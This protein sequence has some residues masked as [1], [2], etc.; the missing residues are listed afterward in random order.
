MVMLKKDMYLHV[1]EGRLIIEID[2]TLL[3]A[4]SVCDERNADQIWRFI[5]AYVSFLGDSPLPYPLNRKP[6]KLVRKF[7]RE[8]CGGPIRETIARYA[9]LAEQIIT[10]CHISGELPLTGEFV[11][12][13]TNTPVFKEYHHFY[14]TGDPVTLQ[15]ILS[16]LRFGKKMDYID[17]S[18]N[19]VA[20]RD[21][22][23]VENRLQSLSLPHYVS[24]I[25]KLMRELLPWIRTDSFYPKFG[26][27]AVANRGVRG[28]ISKACSLRYDPLI[29]RAFFS[30][31]YKKGGSPPP[32]ASVIPDMSLWMDSSRREQRFS[33]YRF[34]PKDVAKSRSI[35]ME[36]NTVMY[37]QQLV[38]D[39]MK[40]SI[41]GGPLRRFIHLDDQDWNRDAARHGS[42]YG[43]MDTLDLSSA[44]DSVS[45]DLVKEI[46]PRE[47]LYY[48]LATRTH[49]VR[50]P[51]KVFRDVK[52]FAP[53]GSA[54]CF[55][56]QCIIFCCVVLYAMMLYD[57][58]NVP[59]TLLAPEMLSE[60][61]VRTFLAKRV[62]RT[63]DWF[64][65]FQDY[66]ECPQVFGDDILCDSRVTENVTRILHDL[67]FVVNET[68]SFRGS[69]A[70]RES[71]GEWYYFGDRVTPFTYRIEHSGEKLTPTSFCSL[72]DAINNCFDEGYSSLR[73]V[74]I[75]YALYTRLPPIY[76]KKWK[77]GPRIRVRS[78]PFGPN[79]VRFVS[80]REEFGILAKDCSNP[81]LL[82][83]TNNRWQV[84]EVLCVG[85]VVKKVSRPESLE[86]EIFDAYLY[87]QDARTRYFASTPP[88]FI[89][90][91]AKYR[92]EETG[93]AGRW[94]PCRE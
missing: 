72:I 15:F 60:E 43:S 53:M 31:F 24:D 42:I 70:I 66:F 54:V 68:K 27:G 76:Y 59:G 48:M 38:H 11:S 91:V 51:D 75:R 46:F 7:I 40:A 12:E 19:Q 58:N 34:V 37:F 36:P 86:R 30:S 83:R 10:T 17:E 23:G 56:T 74:L 49:I 35:C 90:G 3:V 4:N 47:F 16:F 78:A 61:G 9:S 39:W 55:P 57:S 13:M 64:T 89:S 63:L 45:I 14:D 32:R 80:Q 92:P 25:R 71:C 84:E 8:L 67:G 73:R 69:Q 94:I 20:F 52:K 28:A 87:L 82:Q 65:P 2:R 79:P 26:P 81:H 62:G 22:L 18:L 1:L 41:N 33:E 93:L 85:P 5:V 77:K 44:S 29:D 21:W 50:T 6:G 88:D